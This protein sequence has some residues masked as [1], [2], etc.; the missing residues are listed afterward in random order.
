M[1][2]GLLETVLA[3]LAAVGLM[4]IGWLLWM[5][6][7]LPV[8]DGTDVAAVIAARGDAAALEQAVRGLLWLRRQKL[9]RGRI[10]IVDRGLDRSGRDLARLLTIHGEDIDLCTP[11]E[12]TDR[13]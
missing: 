13:I 4:G 1:M 7:L 10:V 11:E 8:G 2:T 12:L 9:W 3:L 6:W 5:R